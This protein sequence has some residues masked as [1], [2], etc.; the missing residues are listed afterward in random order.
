MW[1]EEDQ[2]KISLPSAVSVKVCVKIYSD[3]L[4]GPH[5]LHERLNRHNYRHF[6]EEELS[7]LM[8]DA[9][10]LVKNHL[11]FMNNIQRTKCV[12]A[13]HMHGQQGLRASIHLISFYGVTSNHSFKAHQLI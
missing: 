5:F 9:P 10:S 4:I 8:E 11:W 13:E 3:Y 6:L 2:H 1:A 7:A 12:A